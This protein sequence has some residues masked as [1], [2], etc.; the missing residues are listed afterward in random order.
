[1]K[2]LLLILALFVVGCSTMQQK[3]MNEVLSSWAGSHIDEVIERWGYPD[4]ERDVA[5]RQIYI[6]DYSYSINLP[7]TITATS[8]RTGIISGGGS[9]SGLCRRILEVNDNNLVVMWN[10]SGN[11]CPYYDSGM[12]PYNFWVK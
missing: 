1:M 11:N 2:N 3:F 8:D 6:W 5:G 9:L 10:Y 4:A 12:R 7:S